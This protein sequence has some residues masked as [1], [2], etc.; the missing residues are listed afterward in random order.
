MIPAFSES[1]SPLARDPTR[2]AAVR[3]FLFTAPTLC[4]TTT[5]G[6]R[7]SGVKERNDV[8]EAGQRSG[9]ASFYQKQDQT[10]K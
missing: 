1:N 8:L 6:G 7:R 2:W 5:Q 9:H 4:R 3:D 10:E